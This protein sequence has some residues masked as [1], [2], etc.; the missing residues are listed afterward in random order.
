MT[1]WNRDGSP[2]P[3]E[4]KKIDDRVDARVDVQK[5]QPSGLATLGADGKV[6][7]GQLPAA[8]GA[9]GLPSFF[10]DEGESVPGGN[11]VPAFYF[12]PTGST[13]EPEPPATP[14]GLASSAITETSFRLSWSAASGATSYQVRRDGETETGSPT[15]AYLD[16]TGLTAGTAYDM[17]VRAVNGV[18]ASSWSTVLA[19]STEGADA[20]GGTYVSIYGSTS[21]TASSNNDGGTN[22]FANAFYRTTAAVPVRVAGVRIFVPAGAASGMLNDPLD[23]F[24]WAA[25]WTGGAANPPIWATPTRTK[26]IT[27]ARTTGWNDL[28]FDT[29]VTFGGIASGATGADFVWLGYRYAGATGYYAFA[30]AAAAGGADSIQSPTHSGLYLAEQGFPRAAYQATGGEPGGP[31]YGIDGLFEVI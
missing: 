10:L 15:T 17:Q 11:P 6:P 22:G 27:A 13:P 9:V 31:N 24:A 8:G 1:G 2:A 12:R 25:D 30:N 18:G 26:R 4:R 16:L 7:P 20:P 23:I 5:G 3:A 29:P 21:L 14:T 28:L 19:V